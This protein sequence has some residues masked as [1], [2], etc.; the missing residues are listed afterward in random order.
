MNKE[1]AQ[2]TIEQYNTVHTKALAN[3]S[4]ANLA[5]RSVKKNYI[6]ALMYELPDKFYEDFKC[7]ELEAVGQIPDGPEYI[8]EK[9]YITGINR[10]GKFETIEDT[11]REH[12]IHSSDKRTVKVLS[13]FCTQDLETVIE[14]LEKATTYHS[15]RVT[16]IREIKAMIKKAGITGEELG[17]TKVSYVPQKKES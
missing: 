13:D 15:E 1:T 5:L 11:G 12:A 10:G 9:L 16:R 7:I 3:C 17:F 6:R 14:H 8:D 2:F 4:A